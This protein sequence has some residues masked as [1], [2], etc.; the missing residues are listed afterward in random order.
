MDKAE[1]R[2]EIKNRLE[3][4]SADEKAFADKQIFENLLSL[5][6]YCDARSVFVYL[7]TP[8][9]VDTSLIIK[10]CFKL[11][12]EV[13]VPKLENEN[14]LMV[15][16]TKSTIIKQNKFGIFEPVSLDYINLKQPYISIVP[17]VG[18]DN[19]LNR[20][21]HGKAYYDKFFKDVSTIKIGIAY[22]CQKVDAISA[23][24]HDVKMDLI[25]SEKGI[26]R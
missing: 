9:E 8:S 26:Y 6:Q 5:P 17:L 19:G 25:I 22:E 21:G 1:L 16:Y 10:N 24:P 14:M 2:K 12:K 15:R 23:Q 18:F 3:A 20:L 13:F 7:N 4:F 11:G